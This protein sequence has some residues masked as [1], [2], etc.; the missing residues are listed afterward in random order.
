MRATTD[1]VATDELQLHDLVS[2]PA[3]S[4]HRCSQYS[5]RSR[6]EGGLTAVEVQKKAAPPMHA[7]AAVPAS[8]PSDPS[9]GR[10]STAPI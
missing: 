6:E 1:R 9:S 2:A 10:A 7:V 5:P 3:W 4:V 8:P